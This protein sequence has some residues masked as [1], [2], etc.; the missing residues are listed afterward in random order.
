MALPGPFLGAAFRFL[1]SPAERIGLRR[2]FDVRQ[3]RRIQAVAS[4]ITRR[5]LL[6][7]EFALTSVGALQAV[8]LIT[9]TTFSASQYCLVWWLS[10]R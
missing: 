2:S 4:D 3:A 5:V 9:R 8:E 7:L 10:E 1:L 6:Y